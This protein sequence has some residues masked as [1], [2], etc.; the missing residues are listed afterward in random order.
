MQATLDAQQLSMPGGLNNGHNAWTLQQ[1][2]VVIS[3]TWQDLRV[4]LAAQTD[5]PGMANDLRLSA[6]TRL[7]IPTKQPGDMG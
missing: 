2:R 3:N 5:I 6:N 4:S 7:N 1:A